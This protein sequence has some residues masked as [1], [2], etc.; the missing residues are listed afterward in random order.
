MH[1]VDNEPKWSGPWIGINGSGIH[2]HILWCHKSCHWVQP[3]YNRVTCPN[4]VS[5]RATKDNVIPFLIQ[6]KLCHLACLAT[7]TIIIIVAVGAV[8][9]PMGKT[10]VLDSVVGSLANMR[11]KRFPFL[12]LYFDT[13]QSRVSHETSFTNVSC[14]FQVA[15]SIGVSHRE[16]IVDRVLLVQCPNRTETSQTKLFK[17]TSH[18]S[19]E[20]KIGKV[21]WLVSTLANLSMFVMLF[22]R[23]WIRFLFYCCGYQKIFSN[24]I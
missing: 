17:C 14:V 8:S 3:E 10:I 5:M 7:I 6:I 23:C 2:T 11:K 4:E 22:C 1:N 9:L 13:Q 19:K 18:K 21:Q 12:F 15:N 20:C 24:Q 16:L